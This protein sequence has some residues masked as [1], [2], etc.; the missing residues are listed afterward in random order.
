MK[1][2]L[3]TCSLSIN[4]P[5]YTVRIVKI[6]LIIDILSE[7]FRKKLMIL[8]FFVLVMPVV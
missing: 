4:V 7:K 2:S 1:H 3:P 8:Y 5:I 6:P